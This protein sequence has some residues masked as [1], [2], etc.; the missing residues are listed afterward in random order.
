MHRCHGVFGP[1]VYRPRATRVALDDEEGSLTTSIAEPHPQRP[2]RPVLRRLVDVLPST[3]P[4]TVLEPSPP[5]TPPTTDPAAF[6]LAERV[7]RAAVELLDGRRPAHQLSAV[8]PPNLL[9]Y[10]LAL[11]ATAGHLK[12]RVHKVVAQQ[13]AA[14]AL[15]AV[16]LVTLSTGVRAL[17][18]R[19]EKHLDTHGSRWRCTAFQLRLTTGDLA[20]RRG[21]PHRP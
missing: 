3:A 6:A 14:G 8:L 21:R 5:A 20:T 18:A 17:A 15:E 11:Q 16:A 9:T 19:F 12:P 1:A 4:A 2:H 13:H 7:L 10:L